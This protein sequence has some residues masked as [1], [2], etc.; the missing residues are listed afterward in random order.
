MTDQEQVDIV[1]FLNT[2]TD[3]TLNADTRFGSPFIK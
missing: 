2:L 1:A 3:T